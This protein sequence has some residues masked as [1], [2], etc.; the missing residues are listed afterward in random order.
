MHCRMDIK[1]MHTVGLCVAEWGLF[2][3]F[4]FCLHCRLATSG[5]G[6]AP[7][8]GEEAATGGERRGTGLADLWRLVV[9][10]ERKKKMTA[11]YLRAAKGP[12]EEGLIMRDWEEI[13]VLSL[14]DIYCEDQGVMMGVTEE[15]QPAAATC[16]RRRPRQEIRTNDRHACLCCICIVARAT[17]TARL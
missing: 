7:R 8:S 17:P 4:N 3:L 14:T 2:L 13:R 10:V 1:R 12:G 5:I 11:V 15:N 9:I 6:S 16:G